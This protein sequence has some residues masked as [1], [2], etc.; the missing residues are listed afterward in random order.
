MTTSAG[1]AH[2]FTVGGDMISTAML[3]TSVQRKSGMTKMDF[4]HPLLAVILN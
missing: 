1:S 3:L 2:I 4:S